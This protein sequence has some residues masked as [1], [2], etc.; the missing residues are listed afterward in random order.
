MEIIRNQLTRKQNG[1]N[2]IYNELENIRVGSQESEEEKLRVYTNFSNELEKT[3]DEDKKFYYHGCRD[4]SLVKQIIESK[5]IVSGC[6]RTGVETSFDVSG[7]IS[8]TTIKN[9][10]VTI[11]GYAGLQNPSYLPAGAVFVINPDDDYDEN[12]IITSNVNFEDNN[13]LV[14]IITTTEN[15]SKVKSWLTTNGMDESICFS[16]DEF[17]EKVNF[18]TKNT[19]RLS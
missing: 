18:I 12:S 7:T 10:E 13:K 14:A 5:K 4:I 11:Q 9:L 2:N 17:L 1:L 6:D 15:V 16:Y 19:N 3:I 8:I